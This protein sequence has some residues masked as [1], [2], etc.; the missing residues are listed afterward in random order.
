MALTLSP[1]DIVALRFPPEWEDTASAEAVMAADEE[2]PAAIPVEPQPSYQLASA[3]AEPIPPPRQRVIAA[4]AARAS[5]PVPVSRPKPTVAKTPSGRP[6]AVFN[7][8]QLASI[9]KRLKLTPWQERDW[10]AVE[11]ALRELSYKNASGQA[12]SK[13]ATKTAALTHATGTIDPDSPEVQRLKSAAVPLVMSFN[14]EQKSEVRMMAH[15]IGLDRLATS[16]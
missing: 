15:L 4:P 10:P 1:A 8:A 9:K 2:S 16:F 12:H 13:Q 5:A 6:G 3:A 7:D 11:A 14:E